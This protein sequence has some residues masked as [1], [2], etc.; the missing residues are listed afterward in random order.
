MLYWTILFWQRETHSGG[1]IGIDLLVVNHF[2]P[3][4]MAVILV[5]KS[6]VTLGSKI[7]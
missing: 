7:R 5:A 6:K 3:W 1:G 4:L 2:I